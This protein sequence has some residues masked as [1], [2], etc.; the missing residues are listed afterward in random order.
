MNDTIPSHV[1][2]IMEKPYGMHHFKLAC[3]YYDRSSAERYVKNI[4]ENVQHMPN[5]QRP[6]VTTYTAK[7]PKSGK[8]ITIRLIKEPLRTNPYAKKSD[9]EESLNEETHG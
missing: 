6:N 1:Y 7:M 9:E 2:V 5:L 8:E 4:Y 3:V